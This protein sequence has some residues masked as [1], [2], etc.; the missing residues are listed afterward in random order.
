M[1]S[2]NF[3][4]TCELIQRAHWSRKSTSVTDE[5]FSRYSPE[6]FWPQGEVFSRGVLVKETSH[7]SVLLT[8][9]LRIPHTN[10][11]IFLS[12]VNHPPS[13]W[14]YCDMSVRTGAPCTLT[15]VPNVPT[16]TSYQLSTPGQPVT[17]PPG[18]I[19]PPDDLLPPSGTLQSNHRV[20]VHSWTIHLAPQILSVSL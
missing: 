10:N 14:G 5:S 2:V 19:S 12:M 20:L 16:V 13:G 18:V 15:P 11:N 8:S 4:S 7:I 17:T 6:L 1:R 3:T 9:C